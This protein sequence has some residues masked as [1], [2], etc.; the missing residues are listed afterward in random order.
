M[1]YSLGTG[2]SGEGVPPWG[3]GWGLGCG[4]GCGS[5]RGLGCAS[6]WGLGWG[7]GFFLVQV[8]LLHTHAL[9]AL[10]HACCVGHVQ[11]LAQ[12]A[13]HC[14]EAAGIAKGQHSICPTTQLLLLLLI[15]AELVRY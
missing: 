2:P 7:S 12:P 1:E 4:L 5:G 13:E 8:S 3:G 10:R 9:P 11:Y 15:L 6:G 14:M